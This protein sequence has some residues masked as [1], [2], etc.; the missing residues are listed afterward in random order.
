MVLRKLS[1]LSYAL[2]FFQVCISEFIKFTFIRKIRI[3]GSEVIPVPLFHVMDGR[4]PQDY[5]ARVEP[6]PSGGKKMA[7][8]ILDSIDR[9][10]VADESVGLVN[11]SATPMTEYMGDR[12]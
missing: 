8:F 12:S 3:P 11:N 6:S 10:F 1:F 7:E 5:I 2:L 9:P 4:T